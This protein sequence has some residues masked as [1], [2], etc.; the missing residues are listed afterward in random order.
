INQAGS[1]DFS[2]SASPAS[3]TV[4]AG[5]SASYTTTIGALSGF[6]GT[7]NLSISGLPGGGTARFYST[8]GAGA[9]RGPLTMATSATTP[10]GNYTLTMTGTSGTLT[11]STTVVLVVNAVTPD[12]S[13]SATP[14]SQTVTRGSSTTYTVTV[15]SLNGFTGTVALSATGLP[16]R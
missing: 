16:P 9:W 5:G 4:T 7:V 2:I 1:P 14:A 6:A 12:F 10:A 15:G 8:A 13:I 11:H 3:Q